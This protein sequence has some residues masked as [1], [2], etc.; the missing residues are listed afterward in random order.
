MMQDIY[1]KVLAKVAFAPVAF[2]SDAATAGIIIDTAGFESGKMVLA[3]GVVTTGDISI[4]KI[5]EGT[6]ASLSDASDIPA[7]R[8][9]GT[10][11]TAV[12]TS[13]TVSELGFITDVKHRYVRVTVTTANSAALLAGVI[14]ELGHPDDQPIR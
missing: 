9:I 11:G 8:L 12:T 10:A 5:E 4:T 14:C 7:A 6:D 1:S 13:N 3:T 2:S